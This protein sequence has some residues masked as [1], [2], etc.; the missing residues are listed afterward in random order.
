MSEEKKSVDDTPV[1]DLVS[2]PPQEGMF[3]DRWVILEIQDPV[4]PGMPPYKKILSG[5][6][7]GYLGSDTWRMSSPID[8]IEKHE[9]YLHVKTRSGSSYSLGNS[10]YGFTSLTSGVFDDIL[11]Q[12]GNLVK[13]LTLEDV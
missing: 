6:Q 8:T 4:H 13:L 3:P 1:S 7:G 2:L 5:I 12:Y 9:K 11:K 10:R